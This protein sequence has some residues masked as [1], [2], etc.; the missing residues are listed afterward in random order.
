MRDHL[1]IVFASFVFFSSWPGSAHPPSALVID[2]QRTNVYFAYWG[3]TWKIDNNDKLERIHSNDF[4]WLAL[5]VTS[6]FTITNA[7]F[8][9]ITPLGSK[10]SLF[11]FSD[12]PGTFDTNGCLY[13]AP[14][15]PGRIRLE[16]IPPDGKREKFVDSP[17]NPRLA[18]KPNRHE[19]G[20]IAIT[21]GPS[22]Q[23]VVSDGASIWIVSGSGVVTPFAENIIVSNCAEDLPAELP[24]PHI[25]SLAVGAGGEIYAA[26]TGC[27]ATL[28]IMPSG[29][30]TTVLRSETPWTPCAVVESNGD[31]YVMEYDNAVAEW[32]QD[33]RPRIRRLSRGRQLEVLAVMEKAPERKR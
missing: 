24:K 29:A 14:W 4:H 6:R 32:P 12:F 1:A 9:L 5:D 18:R 33:G 21:T 31:L 7:N 2:P 13:L 17:I 8:P 27:R 25:R 15:S 30:V 28:R 23:V 10:P 22:G 11:A 26:A 20:I 16:R 19:G 3:G